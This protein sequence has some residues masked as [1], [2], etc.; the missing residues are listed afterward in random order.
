MID[1]SKILPIVTRDG[2]TTLYNSQLDVTYR[3]KFGASAESEHVFLQGTQLREL[4]T[5]TWRVGE[6]GFGAASNF[7]HT[8]LAAR[9]QNVHLEYFSL[10]YSPIPADLLPDC[11]WPTQIAREALLRTDKDSQLPI[12]VER[13]SITLYLY[14][15]SWQDIDFPV[16]VD[17]LFHDPFGP[18]TNPES[19]TTEAFEWSRRQLDQ[20]GRL[21]TYSAASS[22]KRALKA[23]GFEILIRKG[24]PHSGG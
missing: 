22:V 4:N 2:S 7:C 21:A 8:A 11:G 19:W 10:D 17:A 18:K 13:D 9:E 14:R 3:S 23:A 15:C 24:L 16:K 6:L 1:S 12:K 5:E 20:Q